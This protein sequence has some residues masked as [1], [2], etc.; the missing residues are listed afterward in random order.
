MEKRIEMV[1]NDVV[2]VGSNPMIPSAPMVDAQY[3]VLETDDERRREMIPDS[4]T[5][6]KAHVESYA[7]SS[8]VRSANDA[9][10]RHLDADEEAVI[11]SEKPSK[12]EASQLGC[13]ISA[14][15]RQRKE[16]VLEYNPADARYE[17]GEKNFDS[18]IYKSK[19][20]DYTV[21][22]HDHTKEY[23]FGSDGYEVS[24]YKFES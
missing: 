19:S 3:V 18:K 6:Y 24:D 9:H 5:E 23:Q 17:E 21:P 16:E 10:N 11:L 4:A 8:A 2:V 15:N 20:T 1:D 13:A 12:T 14:Q 22:R 7:T